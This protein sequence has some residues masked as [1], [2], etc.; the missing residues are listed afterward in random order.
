M[1]YGSTSPH[2]L[3]KYVSNLRAVGKQ[4]IFSTNSVSKQS[5]P[6]QPRVYNNLFSIYFR[7]ANTY[8]NV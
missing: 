6:D 8:F 2:H 5:V 7:N 3:D 1:P 4:L